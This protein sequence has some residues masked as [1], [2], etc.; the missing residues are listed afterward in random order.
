MYVYDKKYLYDFQK[1]LSGYF[2]LVYLIKICFKNE[3]EWN[4]RFFVLNCSELNGY[5]C[6]FN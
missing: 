4:K 3:V 1:Q 6:L 5:M 2:F